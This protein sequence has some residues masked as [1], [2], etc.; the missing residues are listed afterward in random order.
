M[1]TVK[2]FNRL[3]ILFIVFM[4]LSN[5]N[6]V[7]KRLEGQEIAGDETGEKT[8]RH[9]GLNRTYRLHIPL[10]HDRNNPVPLVIA[11]HGGGGTGYNMEKL[12]RRGFNTLAD[13]EG[14]VVVYPDGIEK[15]WNDGRIGKEIDDVG[16]IST[17]IDRLIKEYNIDPK[18]IYVTGMSNGAIMSYRLACELTEK[19]AAIAPVAGNMPQNIYPSCSPSMPISVLA[20]NNANDPLVPFAGGNI[21]GPFGFKKLGKVL[22]TYDTIG[23]WVNNNN[24][25]ASPVITQE[26]DTDPKD[27]TRVRKEVYGNGK[28]RTDVILYV[29]EGGGHTWPGGYQ[30]LSERL[31]GKTSK[32][33]NANEIIWDFFKKHIRD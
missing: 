27:G 3:I 32:D 33:I 11:L 16:F 8:I 26:P 23:F 14:F 17:L 29:I 9:R 1:G 4:L 5:L 20:I 13:R 19:I 10:S 25:S 12:S 15:S 18:R 2:R 6:C 30:Y 31:I 24:C 22:S 28:N 21:T 7:Q